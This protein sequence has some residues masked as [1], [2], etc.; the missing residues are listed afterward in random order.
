M[1]DDHSDHDGNLSRRIEELESLL[2]QQRLNADGTGE[3]P[4]QRPAN[5]PILDEVVTPGD[6][7]EGEGAGPET[8]AVR[9]L[10]ELADRLEKKFSRELDETVRIL[11]NNLRD[12]ILREL[13][14]QLEEPPA[15]GGDRSGD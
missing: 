4:P 7:L 3:E 15:G 14:E 10:N 11:K 12:S 6:Y 1:P 2:A 5:I 13:D 9:D 8:A